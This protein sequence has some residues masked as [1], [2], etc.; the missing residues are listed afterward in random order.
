MKSELNPNPDNA[1]M[2]RIKAGDVH[3]MG[4]LFQRYGHRMYLYFLRNTG[5]R[6]DAEDLL[7]NL[8]ERMLKY[9]HTYQAKAKFT[10]WMYQIANNLKADYYE[11]Q[12]K[13]LDRKSA[14][15]N[16]LKSKEHHFSLDLTDES[17]IKKQLLEHALTQLPESQREVLILGK[18]EGLRYSEIGKILDCSEGAVKVR[19]YRAV[20]ELKEICQ[21]L[22]EELNYEF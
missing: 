19:I 2:L 15:R 4:Q 6:A 16:D 10:T 20:K 13:D 17:A 22:V 7:Q 8:F 11:S 1:L 21:R 3:L 12:A 5:S 9:R 18:Y 14:Y